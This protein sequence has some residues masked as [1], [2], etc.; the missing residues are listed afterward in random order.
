MFGSGLVS[1]VDNFGLNGAQPTHPKLLDYLAS[2]FVQD[3]WSVKR[4]IKR[5]ALSRTYR[6]SAN[7]TS[8]H[9]ANDPSNSLYWRHSPRRLTAEEVRDAMLAT[10][11]RLELVSAE[12][13]PVQKLKMRE[14][15]D[16]GPEAA[17]IQK[18]SEESRARSVYLPLLRGVVPRS[19]AVFDPVEQTLVT[20]RETPQRSHR[21][22]CS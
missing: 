21:R 9:L 5:L 15:R 19:L 3:D 8:Q 4:L 18:F 12:V 7:A 6:L 22:R 16:N 13:T 1:T 14:L 20:G 2:E 17:Q 10:A 11:S